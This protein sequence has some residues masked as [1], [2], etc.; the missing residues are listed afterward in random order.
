M[1]SILPGVAAGLAALCAGT[2]AQAHG[3][4]G[5]RFF[6]A[7]IATDDPAVADE[8]SLP[9][10]TWSRD[11]DAPPIGET[12]I[13]LE[14]SK[15][16]TSRL[17]VSIEG[18]WTRLAQPG[19]ATAQGFQNLETTLKYQAVTSAD[20]EAIISAGV[21]VEWG[22]SGAERVGAEDFSVVTPTVWFGKGFGD[23]PQ[24][25]AWA[26]PF[27][28]TGLVG[29]AVPTRGGETATLET[30]LSLQYSLRYLSAHVR[31]VGL[32]RVVNQLTPLVELRL[33]TPMRNGAGAPTVG[34]VNPGVL[35][36]GRR[37]QIGLEA[38]IPVNRASGRGLGVAVQAHWFLDDLFPRSLGKPIW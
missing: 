7:T 1:R 30:G 6:P 13:A 31:D 29:Y 5:N 32:P 14:Y 36:S 18:A 17:G 28:V 37:L 9:T 23:L 3:V 4:A 27:A 33:S 8:L 25:A 21:S 20:H 2:G 38:V 35:W 15:R 10:V 24:G 34:T 26:R 22:A 12:E 11:D 19:A 16:L